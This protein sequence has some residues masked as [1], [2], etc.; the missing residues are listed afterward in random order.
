L[1]AYDRRAA[2][3]Q[4]TLREL[5]YRLVGGAPRQRV[6]TNLIIQA[7]P[8]DQTGFIGRLVPRA[9]G[10]GERR[11]SGEQGADVVGVD[12]GAEDVA[13]VHDAGE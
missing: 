3:G 11:P 6:A 5:A 10:V 7:V 9:P 8:S 4:P 12:G 2:Q 13:V 1:L